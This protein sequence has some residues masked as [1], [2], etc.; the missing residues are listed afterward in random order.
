MPRLPALPAEEKASIVLELIAGRIKLTAAASQAGV[1]VQ[2][3]CQW[4]RQFIE[5]GQQGLQ[6]STRDSET[7]RRERQ[8][9]NEIRR[10]K[11]ALGEAHL[12]L[13]NHTTARVVTRRF[14]GSPP[15]LARRS[16]EMTTR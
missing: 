3:I 2:S 14:P 13:R 6:P 5:A 16:Q 7:A 8:L 9:L 11:A 10:L 12:N 4:R 15:S 1:S